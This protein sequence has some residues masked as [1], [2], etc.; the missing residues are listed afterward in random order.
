MTTSYSAVAVGV[1][2]GGE[3]RRSD[4]GVEADH[5]R[6]QQDGD[7]MHESHFGMFLTTGV[8]L[9]TGGGQ[10]WSDTVFW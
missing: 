4:R 7:A 8:I 1:G 3:H 6:Q 5:G 9:A 2:G 10:A